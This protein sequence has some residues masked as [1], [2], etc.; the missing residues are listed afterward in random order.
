MRVLNDV[1]GA[2]TAA[3]PPMRDLDGWLIVVRVRRALNLHMLTA[4]GANA[5]ETEATRMPAPE[6]PLLTQLGDIQTAEL[7][8][9]HIEYVEPCGR[10]VHL[11]THFVRH[12][13]KRDDEALPVATS[14]A[15]LPLVLPNGRLLTGRGLNRSHSIVFRVPEQLETLLP[16]A[17]ACTSAAVVDAMRFLT[18]EWLVDVATDYNGKCA[19]IALALSIIQRAL[20]PERPAYMISAGQRSSGKTTVIN[21]VSAAVLGR[22]AAA[23]AWSP[24]EEERRKA[25]FSYLGDGVP[26]LV[27]DNIPRGAAISCPSIEKALT[28]ETYTDRVLGFTLTRTVPASTVQVFTGNNVSA[29]GDMA[30][31]TLQVRL[32]VDRPDPENREFVHADPISWTEA[33]RG[34]I[35]AALYTLLLGNPRL[36]SNDQAAA[37]TRFKTWWH[38]IGSPIEYAASEH[39]DYVRA[40]AVAQDTACPPSRVRFKTMFLAGEAD[41]EQTSSLAIV[42]RVLREKWRNGCLARDVAAFAGVATEEAIEFKVALEQASGRAIKVV[43]AV[44]IT[45]R[46]KA[47]IEAPVQIADHVF[48][49]QYQPDNLGGRF[50]V[51]LIK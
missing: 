20:L 38:L 10:A 27:W 13:L 2:S 14:V 9:R 39:L 28:A 5:D 41:E 36:R 43:T 19:L 3:E 46:L 37:E 17:E 49:L 40:L 29:R 4:L 12:Y 24:S 30:S 22:R 42:L 8:E 21:M 25:L 11:A 33:H 47:L 6:E 26:L 44:V 31:R 15:T 34:K 35:L 16:C 1:L 51:R 7:I 50:V 48:V 23:A 45:W 32:A 18:D